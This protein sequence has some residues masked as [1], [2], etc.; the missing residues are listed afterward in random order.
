MAEWLRY[1]QTILYSADINNTMQLKNINNV[2]KH[3]LSKLREYLIVTGF[4][5]EARH[6]DGEEAAQKA[7]EKHGEW[8]L[9]ATIPGIPWRLWTP[10]LSW[11]FNFSRRTGWMNL[12]RKKTVSDC[13]GLS[14]SR[15]KSRSC[16]RVCLAWIHKRRELLPK[17]RWR[18]L[19]QELAP[20]RHRLLLLHLRRGSRSGHTENDAIVTIKRD[21]TSQHE[22]DTVLTWMCS[23]SNFFLGFSKAEKAKAATVQEHRLQKNH[24]CC[25]CQ[26][27]S[28]SEGAVTVP[29]CSKCWRRLSSEPRPPQQRRRWN[30]AKT[31]RGTRCRSEIEISVTNN[32]CNANF[33]ALI[34]FNDS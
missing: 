24:V 3:H 21:T 26:R 7:W 12:K 30:W 15:T 4:H 9:S 20:C 6:K 18:A 28:V 5:G 25:D 17:L 32:T 1:V 19:L 23:I 22:E 14:K 34:F 16:R 29:A 11:I 10:Q 33:V 8:S 2:R 13:K 27:L 31:S